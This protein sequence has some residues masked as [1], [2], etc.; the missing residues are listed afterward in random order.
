M[1]SNVARYVQLVGECVLKAYD[2]ADVKPQV[3]VTEGK[4]YSKVSIDHRHQ[5]TVHSF[6]SKETGD[7]FKPA[8]WNAPAKDA[9]YNVN[10][11]LELL[12]QVV[13]PYG[14]YLYKRGF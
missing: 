8:S 13:D 2:F 12:Q 11:D 3:V 6:V 14:S 1:M 10:R 9:R 4:K 5:K 7:V